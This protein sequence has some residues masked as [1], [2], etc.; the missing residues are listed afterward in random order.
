MVNEISGKVRKR[1]RKPKPRSRVHEILLR[2]CANYILELSE[3]A[4][5]LAGAEVG[6]VHP[7]EYLIRM[8]QWSTAL[9]QLHE[10]E[11]HHTLDVMKYWR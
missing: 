3:L 5:M 11:R 10:L 4:N 8:N 1:N 9:G 7:T 2:G 6:K